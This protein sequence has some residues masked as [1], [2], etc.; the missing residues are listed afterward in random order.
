M[1]VRTQTGTKYGKVSPS[2]G[3]IP[4][5]ITTVTREWKSQ[6]ESDDVYAD[7]EWV[8][9]K[10][11][12]ESNYPVT[13]PSGIQETGATLAEKYGMDDM[14]PRFKMWW[15]DKFITSHH[16]VKSGLKEVLGEQNVYFTN[17]SESVGQLKNIQDAYDTSTLPVWDLNTDMFGDQW[18]VPSVLPSVGSYCVKEDSKTMAMQLSRQSNKVYRS[19]LVALMDDPSRDNIIPGPIA[20]FSM[21]NPAHG[22]NM[23]CDSQ[24]PSRM[25]SCLGDILQAIEEHLKGLYDVLDFLSNRQNYSQTKAQRDIKMNV[26]GYTV[27]VDKLKHKITDY[28][29]VNNKGTHTAYG[30]YTKY[31][32]NR[33]N[34]Q[35]LGGVED[36]Q[37][38]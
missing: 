17:F 14:V 20:S 30:K 21:S 12:Q 31:N 1:Q 25:H 11:I 35:R 9:E 29:Q 27:A 19:N 2:G 8:Q 37:S 33:T 26:E 6:S 7:G 4:V 3:Q 28:T 22:I 34:A 13:E 18:S 15:M 38:S 24:H 32:N 16:K 10:K 36:V 5:K 23:V